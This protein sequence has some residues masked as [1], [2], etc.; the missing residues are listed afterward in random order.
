MYATGLVAY[1]YPLPSN[2]S[3]HSMSGRVIE[4]SALKTGRV[5]AG[6]DRF[7]RMVGF[8]GMGRDGSTDFHG[9]S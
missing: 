1:H 2:P 5:R 4:Y 7:A 8:G 6:W 9:T 3:I